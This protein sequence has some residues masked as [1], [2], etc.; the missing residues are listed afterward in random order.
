MTKLIDGK[1]IAAELRGQISADVTA[2]VAIGVT[3]G[4]AVV[5]VGEDPASRVYVSMKEKA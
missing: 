3:P 1:A 2:L 4:L 5:L